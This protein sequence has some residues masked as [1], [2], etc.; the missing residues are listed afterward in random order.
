[1]GNLLTHATTMFMTMPAGAFNLPDPTEATVATYYFKLLQEVIYNLHEMAPNG[2]VIHGLDMKPQSNGE[3][4][5]AFHL[6][7]T[8]CDYNRSLAEW[9]A[10]SKP[11]QPPMQE[12]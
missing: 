12:A 2:S 1:M 11:K 8:K 6:Q 7:V 3:I 9:C 4:K 10:M 5:L